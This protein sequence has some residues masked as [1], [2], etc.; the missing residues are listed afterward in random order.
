MKRIVNYGAVQGVTFFIIMT[1]ISYWVDNISFPEA[2]IIGFV[3]G[4]ILG[5]LNSILFYKF[6][7]AKYV[8]D[9]V[10]VDLDTDEKIQFQTPANY[11]SGTEPVSG[12]LFLTNKRFIFKNHKNDKNVQQF[13]IDL[14]DL[15]KADTYKTLGFF[16][17]GLNIYTASGVTHKFI[18]D[19][20]RQWILLAAKKVEI[21]QE[22]LESSN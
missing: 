12:K 16:E 7:V 10:S 20:L 2:L 19:R 3:G 15:K 18:V 22:N 14:E 11:T 4:V 17:N 1:G 21:R 13:S 8:L 6:S 5:I 9:A